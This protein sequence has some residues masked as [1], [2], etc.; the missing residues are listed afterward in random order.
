MLPEQVW[1][2]ADLPEARLWRGG[3]TGSA[4]PLCW[5]HAEYLTLVR[6][7]K[8]GKE[9]D[10]IPGVHERYVKN[11]VKSQREIWTLAHQPLTIRGGNKLR[12]IIAFPATVHWSYDGWQTTHD[13]TARDSGWNCWFA[14]LPTERLP[15][16]ATVVFTFR[17]E[18]RWEGR[19]YSVEIANSD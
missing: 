17:W 1:D 10:C 9:F 3:P 19:D 14:D 11:P 8:D 16:G 4:M 6:S 15:A 18:D 2:E 5:A 13:E 12:L 7:C